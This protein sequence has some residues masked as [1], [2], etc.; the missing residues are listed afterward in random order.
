VRTHNP[1]K[2]KRKANDDPGGRSPDRHRGGFAS[3]YETLLP[4]SS[5]A[6]NLRGYATCAIRECHCESSCA[7]PT[8][9]KESNPLKN[10]VKSK[11]KLDECC[12][13]ADSYINFCN[14]VRLKWIIA[15]FFIIN[16]VHLC[17]RFSR[18]SHPP[19]HIGPSLYQ[20]RG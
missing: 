16:S 9:G 4:N 12:L 6:P 7:N 20:F 17:Y 3:C 14:F 2:W 5:H 10:C 13:T 15:T 19:A 1:L 11:I 18:S 8:R